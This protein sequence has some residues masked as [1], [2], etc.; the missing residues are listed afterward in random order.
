MDFVPNFKDRFRGYAR[1]GG[2]R[3]C[4]RLLTA[5]I[6]VVAAEL[7]RCLAA[8]T[9][10]VGMLEL[11]IHCDYHPGNLKYEDEQGVGLFDFDWS[12]VDYRLFDLALALV[13]FC[14]VWEG[15]RAGSLRAD[16]LALFLSSYN[17][18][19]RDDD[20]IA[21]LTDQERQALPTMMAIANL[22]V[23]NWDLADFYEPVATPVDDEYFKF[24][25]HNLQLMYWIG[26][27][28]ERINQAIYHTDFTGRAARPLFQPNDG[29]ELPEAD[30]DDAPS[31]ETEPILP[32][33]VVKH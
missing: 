33:P 14:S 16:K 12:K 18:Q 8:A 29:I 22:Y 32:E 31:P 27:Q 21:A 20:R 28:G 25:N 15:A 10:F 19:C 24:I 7:D 30:S 23:L 9:S 17:A 1:L 6:D 13:Y 4:D 11:P 2:N 3:R 5:H 26:D